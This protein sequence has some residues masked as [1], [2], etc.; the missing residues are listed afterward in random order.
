MRD[1]PSQALAAYERAMAV[2]EKLAH[3]N[4]RVGLY[5]NE[6]ARVLNL[7]GSL[8]QV[9]DQPA[10]ARKSHA[11]AV[12]IR[13]KLVAENPATPL[14]V[15]LAWS[16]SQ[17]ADFEIASGRVDE[18]SRLY[19][20]ALALATK[21]TAANPPN[22]QALYIVSSSEGGIGRVH[23]E[24]GRPAEASNDSIQPIP[25]RLRG[26]WTGA[27]LLSRPT[28]IGGW[29]QDIQTAMQVLDRQS[30][31]KVARE[32]EKQKE[33]NSKCSPFPDHGVAGCSF[34]RCRL[35]CS[36][37]SREKANGKYSPFCHKDSMSL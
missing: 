28:R 8:H 29:D 16:Y 30:V 25:L 34:S 32:L 5:Q 36:T 19:Q 1:R 11:K 24:Q 20:Q 33:R 3:E 21:L 23:A 4:P 27:S 15:D 2:R 26:I 7:L 12:S 35:T 17:F 13:E 22:P 9:L 14:Q 18:A 6:L 31:E 10:E 37:L